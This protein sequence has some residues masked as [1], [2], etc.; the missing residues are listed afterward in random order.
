M[1]DAEI[2]KATTDREGDE[3]ERGRKCKMR[4][5]EKRKKRGRRSRE[6]RKEEEE[7][8]ERKGERWGGKGV[9]GEMVT[10]WETETEPKQC[11]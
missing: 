8:R 11:I 7:E 1:F 5:K 2:R 6:K 3:K 9:G 10:H 4:K